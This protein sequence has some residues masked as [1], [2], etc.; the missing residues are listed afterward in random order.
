MKCLAPALLLA[1]VAPCLA[2]EAPTASSAADAWLGLETRYPTDAEAKA[3]GWTKGVRWQ[4]Q[5]VV[6]TAEGSP[7]RN[8]GLVAGDVVLALDQHELYSLDDL[9]DFVAASRPGQTVRVSVQ[10]AGAK[11]AAQLEV[12]LQ[13]RATPLARPPLGWQ[14][15]GPAQLAEALKRAKQQRTRVLVGLSGAD[16]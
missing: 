8:S 13:M 4:G 1:V 5:V 11:E 12:V 15:A 3:R 7:A 14:L 10:R 6:K 9:R 16:T 2:Q